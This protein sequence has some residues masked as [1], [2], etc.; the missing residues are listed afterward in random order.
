M[1]VKLPG[2]LPTSTISWEDLKG[3][4][5]GVD[6]SNVCYQFLSSIRQPDGTPLLD[7]K[8]RITSHLQGILSRTAN[9][10]QK[11]ISLCY[12]FDG[13]PPELKFQTQQARRERKEKAHEKYKQA[14][15][16]E[17]IDSMHK[18]S[19]Q[20]TYLNNEIIQE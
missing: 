2:I 4:K 8:G 18:Y 13:K 1:G 19:K 20:V 10:M 15:D 11:E 3:K 17:D 6:F 7:S 5:V 14:K 16:E 9:L 12:I